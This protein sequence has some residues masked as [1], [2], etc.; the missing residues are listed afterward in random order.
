LQAPS[1]RQIC[2]YWLPPLL[3]TGGILTFSGDLGS[4]AHTQEWIA[5]FSSWLPF[6]EVE[7]VQEKHGYLRKAGHVMTYGTLYWLWFRALWGRFSLRLRPAVFWSLGFCLLT[8]LLDEG[9]QSLVPS[10][11]GALLDVALDFGGAALTALALS[12]KRI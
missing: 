3:L 1:V 10:R 12:L 6:L 2:F 4:S 5:W 8:A 11:D 9:R 7:Q